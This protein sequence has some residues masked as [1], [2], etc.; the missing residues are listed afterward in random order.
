MTINNIRSYEYEKN[1]IKNTH[2]NSITVVYKSF[3]FNIM[4]SN[5]CKIFA[6]IREFN[7]VLFIAS[8]K[9]L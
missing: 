9:S 8:M 5:C 3:V 4:I 1:K 6:T 2:K 7:R